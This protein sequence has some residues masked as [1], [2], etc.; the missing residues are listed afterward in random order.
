MNGYE[1]I[2]SKQTTWATNSGISLVGSKGNRGRRAYTRELDQNLFQPLLPDVRKAF[3]DGDGGELGS[4]E[5]SGKMQAVHSS[6]ALG[7]NIFQY[8]K[9]INAVPAIAAQ[10]GLCRRNSQVSNDIYFEE[11]FPI[12]N[13]FGYHPNIDVVIHNAQSAT[14]KRFAIECKFS[15]AYG[16]HKHGG[17]KAKYL[18]LEGLWADIPN[19]LNFA[20]IISPDDKKFVHLHPAQLLKHIL[21]LKR[22]YGKAGFRLLYLWYD[23]FGGQGKRHRDEVIE[24]AEAAEADCIKFHSLTYQQL[25]VNLANKL[26]TEHPDYIRYLTERYL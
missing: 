16:A 7:V 1:Y 21:G 3:A 4:K 10:C 23:V 8:W 22:Q 9:S 24:F 19:L 26:R 12:S 18:E 17:L 11:K 2:L 14:I 13:S 5:F 25:I 20:K 15:E 6:S